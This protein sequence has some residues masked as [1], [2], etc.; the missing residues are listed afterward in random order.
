MDT[1]VE[2]DLEA[3]LSEGGLRAARRAI[4]QLQSSRS[5]YSIK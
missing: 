1:R 3:R 4:R 2:R 5:C